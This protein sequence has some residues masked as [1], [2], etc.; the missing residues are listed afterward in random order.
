M[1]GMKRLAWLAS[2]SAGFFISGSVSAQQLS[3]NSPAQ[4]SVTF[5]P[6]WNNASHV[7]AVPGNAHFSPMVVATHNRGYELFNIGR[8]STPGVKQMAET[9]KTAILKRELDRAFRSGT[10]GS[11]RTGKR[12]EAVD[13]DSITIN[14]RPGQS[15]ISMTSMIAP[16]PD[17]FVG[18][19]N[20]DLCQNG[21]WRNVASFNMVPF[22]A[23]TDS[24][25]SLT[26]PDE[27]TRPQEAIHFLNS[28]FQPSNQASSGIFGSLIVQR[29]GG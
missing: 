23:G 3:C 6:N 12:T 14:A 26:A 22:D 5:A 11:Y 10:V 25:R 4:Y 2:I 28:A 29:I 18:V 24:G 21:V 17:W 9:G 20:Y 13:H 27:A 8:G 7:G 19:S 1:N 15:L 16:S